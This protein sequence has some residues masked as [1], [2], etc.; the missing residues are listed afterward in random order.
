MIKR[1][2]HSQSVAKIV[3]KIQIP[4]GASKGRPLAAYGEDGNSL[5]IDSW[6]FE[7]GAIHVNFG[8]DPVVGS[9]EYEYQIEGDD[10][11]VV[12]GDGGIVNVYVTQNNA[13]KS[14]PQQ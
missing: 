1:G 7:N 11:V 3:W 14:S 10:P 4:E 9:L 8:I 12:S 2:S 13:A 5:E 6:S